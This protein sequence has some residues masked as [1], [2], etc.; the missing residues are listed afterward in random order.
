M[1]HE[2][3]TYLQLAITQKQKPSLHIEQSNKTQIWFYKNP[4]PNASPKT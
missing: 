3:K 1:N 2:K 4:T